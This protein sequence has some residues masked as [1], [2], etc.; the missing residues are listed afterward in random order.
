MSDLETPNGN[1]KISALETLREKQK[2]L[3]ARIAALETKN[4]VQARKEDTRLKVLV[5]AAFLADCEHHEETRA[6][7]KAVI[8]RAI[9]AARDRE[10][11]KEKGWL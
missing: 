8:E 9:T 2:R 5:G 10:F 3:Q 11:L 4:K 7:I 1:G 6:G